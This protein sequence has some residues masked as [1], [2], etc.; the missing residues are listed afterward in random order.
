MLSLA[1]RYMFFATLALLMPLRRVPSNGAALRRN[2]ALSF[3]LRVGWGSGT[4]RSAACAP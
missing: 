1:S 4:R 2:P 3:A